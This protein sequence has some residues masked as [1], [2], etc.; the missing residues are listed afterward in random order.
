MVGRD[1]IFEIQQNTCVLDGLWDRLISGH[2]VE[3]GRMFVY[4]V[5]A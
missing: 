2:S 4:E 3:E 5:V 1:G